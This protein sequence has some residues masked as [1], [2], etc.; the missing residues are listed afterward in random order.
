MRFLASSQRGIQGQ[1][2]C[3]SI[4]KGCVRRQF[5]VALEDGVWTINVFVVR[6]DIVSDLLLI[7]LQILLEERG[8]K[9]LSRRGG[10]GGEIFRL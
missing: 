3:G 9:R 6:L 8:I 7:I 5:S 2:G 10:T 4:S 1:A